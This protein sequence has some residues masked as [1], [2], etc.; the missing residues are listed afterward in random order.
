MEAATILRIDGKA[1]NYDSGTWQK[2]S[3]FVPERDNAQGTKQTLIFG[4]HNITPEH[5]L[6]MLVLHFEI[7]A[8]LTQP[9]IPHAGSTPATPPGVLLHRFLGEIE[10]DTWLGREPPRC[11]AGNPGRESACGFAALRSTAV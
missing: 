5:C 4:D 7:S 9:G 8:N 11:P 6:L 1:F 10:H 3:T 2:P